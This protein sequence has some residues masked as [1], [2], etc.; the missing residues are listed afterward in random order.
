MEK[1]QYYGPTPFLFL[2]ILWTDPATSGRV[3]PM[4]GDKIPG[5]TAVVRVIGGT[6]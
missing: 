2:P 5:S 3:E 6:R 4:R 1:E